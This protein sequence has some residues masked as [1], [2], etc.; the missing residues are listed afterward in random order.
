MVSNVANL[1]TQPL[2]PYLLP[3][4]TMTTFMS[5]VN[6]VNGACRVTV[7]GV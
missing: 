1:F 5:C 6:V 3:L 7:L 2:Q 4:V